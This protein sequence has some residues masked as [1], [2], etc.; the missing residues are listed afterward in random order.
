M[1]HGLQYL[2]LLLI[3]FF[4]SILI[5]CSSGGGDDDGEVVATGAKTH[6]VTGTAATGLA[7]A[8]ATIRAKGQTGVRG[9]GMTDADGKFNVSFSD[10]PGVALIKVE[11][12]DGPD[13][14]SII[15]SEGEGQGGSAIEKTAN[16]HP[17]TDLIVR[18]W[19]AVQGLDIETEFE[20]SSAVAMLPTAS[21]IENIKQ[22]IAGLIKFALLKYTLPVDFDLVESAF[23]ANQTGFDGFLDSSLVVII[24]NNFT[25]ALTDPATSIENEVASNVALT[26]DLTQP[27][28]GAPSTPGNLRAVPASGTEMIVVWDPST[29][30]IGVAGYNVYRNNQLVETTPYPV[31]SDSGLMTGVDYCYEVEAFDGAANT[32]ARVMTSPAC[33]QTI[34]SVDN[35]PPASPTALAAT[36]LGPNSISLSWTQSGVSDVVGFRIYRGSVANINSLVATVTSTAYTDF[37]LLSSTEYCYE[38]LAYDAAG[39]ESARSAPVACATTEAGTEPPP[40]G[41]S[42]VEFSTAL[43]NVT[44]A[45]ATAAIT[46]NRLGDASESISVSYDVS[47]GTA[48][49]GLDFVAASGTLS[50]GVNDVSPK[51]I[52]VQIKGDT[53]A[54]NAETVSLSLINPAANTALGNNANATLTISNSDCAGVLS[55]S[56]TVNTTIDTCTLVTSSINISNGATL[57][58]APGVTL[59]FE[60]NAGFNVQTDG[61]LYAVGSVSDPILF[62]G[63]QPTPGYWRGVQYTFSNNINNELDYVTIEFG[64][65]GYNGSANVVMYGP[66]GSPQRLKIRNTVLTDS[67]GYGFEFNAGSIVDAFENVISTR[68][69]SGPGLLPANIIGVLDANSDYTGNEIDRM[70]VRNSSD[71]DTDQTWPDIN[72]PYFMGSHTIFANLTIAAGAQLIFRAN[73]DINVNSTGS[74]RAQGAA[75]NKILF[76]ADQPT[77]GYWDGIQYTFSN[78]INNV[79]DHVI[80]EYGGGPGGNGDANLVMYGPV[81]SIN[82]IQIT[83]SEFRESLGYGIELDA[84]TI[85]SG[86]SN[87]V[88]T[89]NQLSPVRLPA[90]SIRFL[91]DASTY[92][93]NDID[94]IYVENGDVDTDQTWLNLG[95]P[96]S[97]GSHNI[98]GHLTVAPGNTL[99]FRGGGRFNVDQFGAL[100][101]DGSASL[102][103]LFTAESQSPGFWNGI[104]FTFSNNVNNF[105]NFVTVEYAGAGINGQGN[106]MLYGS[107][108]SIAPGATITNSTFQFSSSYGLWLDTESL[109]NQDIG[110]SNAFGN[111][112]LG[113]IFGP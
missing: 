89:N 94:T 70:D 24:N 15:S 46:V 21:G 38:V 102:P 97:V 53:A 110:T 61:A 2:K 58:I 100:T 10:V 16:I 22:A 54:E 104:Q 42:Q 25:I 45:D 27:D 23:D 6:V 13:L 14:F 1:E 96:F 51:I 101:A 105:L 98:N 90:D 3:S 48:T 60:N 36:P 111:N 30:N 62:T 77:R 26:T 107:S 71:V 69:A 106:V 109:V 44:E 5:A 85:V 74:L 33:V 63:T 65:S 108:P 55:V 64:G 67:V 40:T 20:S 66:T 49:A 47:S 92:V 113:D 86:Y 28:N 80:V 11:R 32:S 88:I 81:A 39:N 31:F 19:F 12:S 95:I 41:A 78:N 91:D 103:I 17:Y 57:T 87:N 79:L 59:L 50:W 82:R 84:G 56:V 8:N 93:G 37:N 75:D 35:T 72:V 4:M 112:T 18:N 29:D 76:T 7:I 43:Y 9:N 73:G 52:Y 99:I 68:N 34:G 83:N